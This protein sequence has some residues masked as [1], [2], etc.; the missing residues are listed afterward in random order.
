MTRGKAQERAAKQTRL[1]GRDA[2]W[3]RMT[4]GSAQAFGLA[5]V[6]A[7]AG[8]S[9]FAVPGFYDAIVPRALPGAARP[10]TLA[11]GVAEIA[12][13]GL[14]ALPRTRPVGALLAAG[15]FIAVFPANIQMAWDSRNRSVAAQTLAYGRLPL[16][17]PLVWWALRVARRV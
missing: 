6:L 5:G 13:A 14:V 16:Q 4:R 12:C 7:G 3:W 10:W 15:L 9:H 17:P 2:R 1:G 8:M 11:S